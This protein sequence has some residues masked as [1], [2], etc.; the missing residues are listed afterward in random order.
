MISSKDSLLIQYQKTFNKEPIQPLSQ[1]QETVSMVG[2]R[3]CQKSMPRSSTKR[4]ETDVCIFSDR[5]QRRDQ[6][7]PRIEGLS[8]TLLGQE[9]EK[10]ITT[11]KKENEKSV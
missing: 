9:M 8:L 5:A 11:E 10:P 1:E 6:V 3:F 4:F 7:V 2:G